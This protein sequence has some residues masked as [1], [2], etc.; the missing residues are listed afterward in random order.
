MTT[1][2]KNIWNFHENLTKYKANNF[3]NLKNLFFIDL[4]LNL[5]EKKV[6][7]FVLT[8]FFHI[9]FF[10]FMMLLM[11]TMTFAKLFNNTVNCKKNI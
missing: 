7:F 8:N 4:K 10:F 6:A 3:R 9:F 2:P 5:K 11:K 1:V